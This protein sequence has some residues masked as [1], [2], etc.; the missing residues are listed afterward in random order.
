[1]N[2]DLVPTQ[3]HQKVSN[4]RESAKVRGVYERKPGQW[5]VRVHRRPGPLPAREGGNEARRLT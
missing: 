3:E 1:M 5:W 2:S 4:R